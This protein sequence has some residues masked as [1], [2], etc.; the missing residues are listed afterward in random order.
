MLVWAPKTGDRDNTQGVLQEVP[1]RR[2]LRAWI[3]R[4][5]W[6]QRTS[7]ASDKTETQVYLKAE[8]SG[9]QRVTQCQGAGEGEGGAV[10][11][12]QREG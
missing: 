5:N 11:R 4:E 6:P 7:T 3:E 10:L 9:K 1:V 8:E 12:Q 2:E